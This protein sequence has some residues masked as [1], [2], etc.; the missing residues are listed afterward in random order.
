[1]EVKFR[2][3][4][5]VLPDGVHEL[6]RRNEA[7]YRDR[8]DTKRL[9]ELFDERPIWSKHALAERTVISK[10]VLKDVLPYI[11]FYWKTGPWARL[12][13]RWGFD[14]S[15]ECL[16]GRRLQSVDVRT[17]TDDMVFAQRRTMSKLPNLVVYNTVLKG[18]GNTED[19][20][21]SDE[22]LKEI[23]LQKYVK[24]VFSK[25]TNFSKKN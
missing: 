17:T 22:V 9:L 7:S 6:L 2:E 21:F 3:E 5:M 19:R 15:K 1:M 4:G 11:A 10:D 16:H 23:R 24:P 20:E 25:K 18:L 14:P 12:W 13:N 8:P